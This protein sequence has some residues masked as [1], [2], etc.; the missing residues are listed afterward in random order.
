MDAVKYFSIVKRQ[1]L[2]FFSFFFQRKCAEFLNPLANIL[3]TALTRPVLHTL[4]SC[5]LL[6]T[7]A[8]FVVT[9]YYCE[10]AVL[11]QRQ[12]QY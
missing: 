4:H 7:F 3:L 8:A 5:C 12:E 6:Y 9:K 1:K 2:G 10:G 11:E